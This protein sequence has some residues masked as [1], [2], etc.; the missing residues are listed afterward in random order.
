MRTQSIRIEITLT[1]AQLLSC[2]MAKGFLN[3]I[4]IELYFYFTKN[5]M[6]KIHQR[7]FAENWSIILIGAGY[8][9][10]T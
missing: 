4:N 6:P 7:V 5:P 1:I 9:S 2:V 3:P 10:L 8:Y